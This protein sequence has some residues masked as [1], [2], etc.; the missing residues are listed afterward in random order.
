M[1]WNRV[2]RNYHDWNPAAAYL[3]YGAALAMLGLLNSALAAA[4][5]VLAVANSLIG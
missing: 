4:V 3:K 1:R 2:R 5:I